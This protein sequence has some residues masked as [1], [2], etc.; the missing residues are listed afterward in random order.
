MSISAFFRKLRFLLLSGIVVAAGLAATAANAQTASIEGT[1]K[2]ANGTEITVAPCDGGFCGTLSWIVIPKEQSGMCKT[3][4][5]ADFASL[6]LD[7]KN[8][9]KTL[10]TRPLIGVQMLTVK[11]T[12]DANA[13]TAKVYNA[14]D[15]STN[16]VLMWVLNGSV[17]RLGGACIGSLC[18]VTQDWPRV[19]TREATPDFTCDGS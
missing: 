4:P 19:E 11:P 14:E 7:Y 13:Y 16:D 5:K 9:D 18:A 6:M 10:Q 3:M 2:T 1:W 12:N 15:G 17:L 8:P